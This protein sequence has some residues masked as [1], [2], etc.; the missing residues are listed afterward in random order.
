M[1]Y[2]YSCVSET[3][4]N[5]KSINFGVEDFIT[6]GTKSYKELVR[7]CNSSWLLKPYPSFWSKKF[8]NKTGLPS[9]RFAFQRS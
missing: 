9:V 7:F 5:P 1:Q 6:Q 4:T 2:S 3:R 8:A